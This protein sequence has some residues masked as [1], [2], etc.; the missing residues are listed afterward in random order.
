MP[1]LSCS[2]LVRRCSD[3][4]Y[5]GDSLANL[6]V[7]GR[8]QRPFG[9]FAFP[10]D[11]FLSTS[12]PASAP[13]APFSSDDPAVI[14]VVWSAAA[15]LCVMPLGRDWL[16]T[17]PERDNLTRWA[18]EG[19]TF[20]DDGDGKS[21]S[22]S[23]WNFLRPLSDR[24]PPDARA[25]RMMGNATFSEPYNFPAASEQLWFDDHENFQSSPEFLVETDILRL[26][27]SRIVFSLKNRTIL[28]CKY[29]WNKKIPS[30]IWT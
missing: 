2:D 25:N 17:G 5:G 6:L 21:S 30:K 3:C 24:C 27:I 28:N 23:N 11:S 4:V 14:D 29:L 12:Q 9:H 10:V 7:T 26:I 15:N 18:P 20:S 1:L 19:G 8:A 22:K 16:T 13:A